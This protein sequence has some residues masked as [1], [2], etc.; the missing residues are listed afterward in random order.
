MGESER[1]VDFCS[2]RS[3]VLVGEQELGRETAMNYTAMN[4]TAMIYMR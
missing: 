2:T 1:A 4:Y 3:G